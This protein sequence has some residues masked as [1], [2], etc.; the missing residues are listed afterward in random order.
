MFFSCLTRVV[1]WVLFE[2]SMDARLSL[3]KILFVGHLLSVSQRKVDLIA[4]IEASLNNCVNIFVEKTL[5]SYPKVE[6]EILE[7]DR[8][9]L[10]WRKGSG[11]VTVDTTFQCSIGSQ[12][13][14][15]KAKDNR[16]CRCSARSAEEHGVTML[17]F[18][19]I[20]HTNITRMLL[21][22]SI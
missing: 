20:F 10:R 6:L 3:S 5:S 17:A 2:Y 13:V 9:G 14:K 4:R 11:L 8:S 18:H 16:C 15:N 1:D 22:T 21:F 19:S 12:K 7:M